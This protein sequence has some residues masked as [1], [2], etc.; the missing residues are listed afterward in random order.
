MV[1][2]KLFGLGLL[3]VCTASAQTPSTGPSNMLITVQGYEVSTRDADDLAKATPFDTQAAVAMTKLA[4]MAKVGRSQISTL[5]SMIASSGWHGV[6]G[7]KS[8]SL[9]VD[10]ILGRDRKTI[11]LKAEITC[12]GQRQ[13]ATSCPPL[14]AGGVGF[15]GRQDHL[16]KDRVRLY[17]ARVILQ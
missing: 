10:A 5:T 9:A 6:V 11:N 17:F 2:L 12:D 4:G 16:P 15:L 14:E 8:F 1:Y 13:P 7:G 3:L